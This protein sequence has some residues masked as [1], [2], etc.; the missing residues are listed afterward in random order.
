[1]VPTHSILARIITG[2][3]NRVRG[4]AGNDDAVPER[5]GAAAAVRAVDTEF[6]I[7]KVKRD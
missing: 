4:S 1:M 7:C 2:T 6:L 5:R 3:R